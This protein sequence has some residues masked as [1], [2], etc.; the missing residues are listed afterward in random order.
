M[1]PTEANGMTLTGNAFTEGQ[2]IRRTCT[3]DGEDTSPALL[4]SQAPADTKSFALICRDVSALGGT[5]IHWVIYNIPAT[6]S[7]LPE[8]LPR[9]EKLTDGSIQ[10]KNDFDLIGYCGPNPPS[11]R[12][13]D[14]HFV[15]YALDTML[16]VEA[17]VNATRLLELTKEHVIATARLMGTYRR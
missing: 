1:I 3:A 4:W 13:H 15:L 6:A 17:G 14:Y 2:A 12:T 9:K 10:G 16:P 8:A 5:F 7:G 11:G